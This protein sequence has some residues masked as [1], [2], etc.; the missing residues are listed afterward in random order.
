MAPLVICD[1]LSNYY[2]LYRI[3]YNMYYTTCETWS[4]TNHKQHYNILNRQAKKVC[5]VQTTATGHK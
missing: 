5:A 4:R 1:T 2:Q 3:L